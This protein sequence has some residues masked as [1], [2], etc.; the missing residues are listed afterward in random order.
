[1]CAVHIGD[2]PFPFGVKDRM[3]NLI[4]SVPDHCLF[5]YFEIFKH[6]P[7]VIASNDG[8]RFSKN[9]AENLLLFT[10]K[11]VLCKYILYKK[12]FDVRRTRRYTITKMHV[13]FA[14]YKDYFD[15][16]INCLLNVY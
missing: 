6:T 15:I 1:M 3:W 5:I 14:F 2:V 9:A 4:V 11:L 10:V 8:E 12:I 13:T 16:F 7:T